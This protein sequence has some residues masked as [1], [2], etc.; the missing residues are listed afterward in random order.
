MRQPRP[1]NRT[2]SRSPRHADF[3][4]GDGDTV[5]HRIAR[6]DWLLTGLIIVL[7]SIGFAVLYSAADGAWQPW[8][9]KQVVR[10]GIGLVLMLMIATVTFNLWLRL[11]YPIYAVALALFL[12]NA[13]T[14]DRAGKNLPAIPR[15]PF[16]NH[17]IKSCGVHN[18]CPL[19]AAFVSRYSVL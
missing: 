10:F 9:A 18:K 6:L 5:W 17:Q 14:T 3:S 15:T 4:S 13:T 11:A 16:P 7:A 8:A 1:L 19:L 2:N 12:A